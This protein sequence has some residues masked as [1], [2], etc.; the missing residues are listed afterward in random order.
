M[1][2]TTQLPRVPPPSLHLLTRTHRATCVRV[3]AHPGDLLAGF[4]R[5]KGIYLLPQSRPLSLRKWLGSTFSA[6][7]GR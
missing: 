4:C 3:H 2:F 7:F 1:L 6:A 5:H